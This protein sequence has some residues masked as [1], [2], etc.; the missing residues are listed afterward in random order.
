MKLKKPVKAKNIVAKLTMPI[1]KP[2]KKKAAEKKEDSSKLSLWWLSCDIED[3]SMKLSGAKDVM[4]LV[5][6]SL[7]DPAPSGAAWAVS[8]I[9]EVQIQRLDKLSQEVMKAH[10]ESGGKSLADWN[11][12]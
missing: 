2:A 5:A 6:T 1:K 12:F 8:D 11:I 9:L 4:E 3:I 7:I 10:R